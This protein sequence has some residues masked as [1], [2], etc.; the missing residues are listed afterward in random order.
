M[1][2]VLITVVLSALPAAV[3]AD[4]VAIDHSPVGCVVAGKHPRI[5]A[6]FSPQSQLARARVYFRADGSPYWYF[7]QMAPGAPCF[8]GTLP[9]PKPS[10]KKLIYYVQALDRTFAE[11]RTADNAPDVVSSAIECRNV[12]VAAYADKAAVSVSAAAGSPAVPVGFVAGGVGRTVIAVIGGGAAVAGGV[13]AGGGGASSTTAPVSVTPPTVPVTS[14]PAPPPPSPTPGPTV[15]PSPAPTAS[16]SVSPEPS[17]TPSSSPTPGPTPT[18]FTLTLT[19]ISGLN[20]LGRVDD[21]Q[22]QISCG[23][24]CSSDTGTYPVGTVVILTEQ[25]GL[26]TFQGWSGACSGTGTTCTVVMNGNKAVTARFALLLAETAPL[27][28]AQWTSLLDAPGATGNVTVNGAATAGVARASVILAVKEGPGEVRVHGVLATGIGPGTWRFERH[29]G[30]G[31]PV[32]V[33]VLEGQVSLVTPDVI[34]F[35]VRGQPGE[36]VAFAIVPLP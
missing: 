13:L 22:G 11:T 9:K 26:L 29:A 15:S 8:V 5:L 4:G 30:T 16:P 20:L 34:V 6:C 21:D 27:A 10:I 1:K 14:P 33:K 31:P 28:P 24:G 36:R 7:V 35:R 2:R 23:T 18:P 17:P 19:K 3:S 12:P 32:R 25:P